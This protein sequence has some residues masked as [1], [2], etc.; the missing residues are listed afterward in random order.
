MNRRVL[1]LNEVIIYRITHIENIPHI[2]H[3]GITHKDSRNK[4]PN[5]KNIGDLSLIETRSKKTVYVDNGEL[6][7]G[8]SLYSINLGN[9]T[10]FYFGVKMPML[11]VAQHG[12]NFVEHAT[13]P[14]DIIYLACSVRSLISLGIN[15]YFTDG[16][17]TD[18]MTS[19]YDSS[20]IIE[21]IDIIDWQAVKS[22][23]WG[24]NENLDIKRKKQ[25]EF[26]V[27]GDLSADLIIGFGCYNEQ[28]RS[29]LI[30]F[31]ISEGRIKIIPNAYY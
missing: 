9:F 7:P 12:G 15:V 4:N 23:Y 30:S 16:H 8:N 28:V 29:K 14:M 10:P 19:F 3:Y 24:G 1:N 26:L 17:A 20:K 31:G 6:N 5:Y 25:A 21:L 13:S 22:S 27:S 18:M 2:L 11:Y